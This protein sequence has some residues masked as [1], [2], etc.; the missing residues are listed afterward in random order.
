MRHP[1]LT[2]ALVLT[3]RPSLRRPASATFPG[4]NGPIAYRT[5][6][7]ESGLGPLF[8]ASP[9]GSRR[10]CSPSSPACSPTGARR[11]DI[12]YDIFDADGNQQIATSKPDGSDL[13]VIT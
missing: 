6:T 8:T 11:P 13:R 1:L 3:A 7:L 10:A 2:T 4:H 12:A 9:N 5:W